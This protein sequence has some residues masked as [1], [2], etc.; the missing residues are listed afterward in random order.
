[1][2]FICIAFTIHL[3]II[4]VNIKTQFIIALCPCDLWL[5]NC[6]G[7]QGLSCSVDKLHRRDVQ[8]TTSSAFLACPM[9]LSAKWLESKW[10]MQLRP[11]VWHMRSAKD[12]FRFTFRWGTWLRN[13][14][15][16]D[17]I[18][19]VFCFHAIEFKE[20]AAQLG[21]DSNSHSS[22]NY[23]KREHYRYSFHERNF[24]ICGKRW[25]LASGNV[26]L[27]LFTKRN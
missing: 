9:K 19:L 12:A 20:I 13:S 24:V 4:T 11:I 15:C 23:V 22:L 17:N 1:M 3:S 18:N 10:I 7:L 16:A 6:V 14:S 2:H 8:F 27:S 21:Y 26:T 5:R 25:F